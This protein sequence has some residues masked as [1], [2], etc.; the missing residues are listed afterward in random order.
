MALVITYCDYVDYI[1]PN[2][3]NPV[4]HGNNDDE[5]EDDITAIGADELNASLEATENFEDFIQTEDDEYQLT[6][7]TAHTTAT[8]GDAM[9]KHTGA[10]SLTSQS[11]HCTE[12]DN[13]LESINWDEVSK[14]IRCKS[15]QE[16][17]MLRSATEL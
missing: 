15:T 16:A 3:I 9:D 13:F 1:I 5:W 8:V 6:F 17:G 14:V 11:Y 7:P 2:D 10:V 4:T 12:E